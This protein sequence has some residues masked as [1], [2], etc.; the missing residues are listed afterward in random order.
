M[1]GK[2]ALAFVDAFDPRARGCYIPDGHHDQSYKASATFRGDYQTDASGRALI[3][4]APSTL[5]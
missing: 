2:L 5:S 3:G 1:A 4:I